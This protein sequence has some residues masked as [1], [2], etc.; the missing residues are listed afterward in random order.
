MLFRSSRGAAEVI[1][2]VSST[3]L[4]ISDIASEVAQAVEAQSV[5]TAEITRTVTDQAT[6]ALAIQRASGTIADL[7]E[8]LQRALAVFHL[9]PG[10]HVQPL[11]KPPA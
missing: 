2:S 11:A 8:D 1:E 9:Q 10:D 7:T 3:I 6:D 5:T 4:A